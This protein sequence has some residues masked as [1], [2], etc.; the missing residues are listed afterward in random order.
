MIYTKLEKIGEGS[1]GKV[2]KAKDEKNEDVAIKI[3][4]NSVF[5]TDNEN[6]TKDREQWRKENFIEF[7]IASKLD[8]P[9]I[10][11]HIRHDFDANY[12]YLIMEY[13]GK[14]IN[15]FNFYSL[16]QQ[17]ILFQLTSALQYLHQWYI[18]R[19]IKPD[20]ILWNGKDIKLI[21]FST[22]IEK[23]HNNYC[24]MTALWYSAP[25]AL[26][27]S[28]NYGVEIDIWSLGCV[29]YYLKVNEHLFTGETTSEQLREI[30][31]KLG[32]PDENIYVELSKLPKW[33]KYHFYPKSTH[34]I[35]KHFD[36]NNEIDLFLK[37]LEYEPSKRITTQQILEHKYFS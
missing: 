17:K 18:H 21:D 3:I 35:T 10:I 6:Y 20:N 27:G 31:K 28:S 37:M 22:S 32:T 12:G 16:N 33:Q 5:D 1:Y 14:P 34:R 25:E 19:D 7:E 11:K 36:S 15:C 24:N 29:F 8:H 4:H 26:F 23:G 13:G 2:Y 9:N 30:F